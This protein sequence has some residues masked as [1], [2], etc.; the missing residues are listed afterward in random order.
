LARNE[1]Y[2]DDAARWE[3]FA[4]P[5]IAVVELDGPG[6][7]G[8]GTEAVFEVWVTFQD[9]PYP[10]EDISEVKFLL[11]DSAGELA[12]SDA[13]TLVED[14]LYEIVLTPEMTAELAE[15]STRLEAVVVSKTV[16]LPSF[17]SMQFVV[18]E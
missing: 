5:A 18:T 15:G 11:F 7:V 17:S 8:Q 16:A 9:E 2:P 12:F 1:A 6:V 10:A 13:A 14:G 3:R 4:E